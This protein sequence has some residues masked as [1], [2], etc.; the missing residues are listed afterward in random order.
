M[1]EVVGKHEAT[2]LE[3]FSVLHVPDRRVI[4][5]RVIIVAKM[6]NQYSVFIAIIAIFIGALSP[7]PCVLHVTVKVSTV[8]S[9]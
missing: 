7:P 5:T 9:A 4:V 2:D 3:G 1:E 8:C 6:K